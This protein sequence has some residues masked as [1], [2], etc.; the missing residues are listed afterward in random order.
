[1]STVVYTIQ[2]NGETITTKPVSTSLSRADIQAQVARKW[3]EVASATMNISANNV[4][5]FTLA[6]GTKQ[7]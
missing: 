6:T 1:M 4:I 2:H 7:A 5:T 3:P